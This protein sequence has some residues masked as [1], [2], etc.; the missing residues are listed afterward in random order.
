M[1]QHTNLS[2]FNHFL[3]ENSFAYNFSK[4]LNSVMV[5]TNCQGRNCNIFKE[6]WLRLS[7]VCLQLGDLGSIPRLG[8][9]SGEGNGNPLQDSCLENPM[10]WWSLLSYS[11]WG[12]KESDT[13]KRLHFH[14]LF[15]KFLTI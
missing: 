8:R 5:T 14:F 15:G 11:P 3:Q 10:E 9:S 12:H 6:I 4:P 2:S 1:E 7:S 13:T